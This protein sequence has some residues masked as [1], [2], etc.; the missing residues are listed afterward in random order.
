MLL[1][2]AYFKVDSVKVIMSVHFEWSNL[3]EMPGV[4]IM[5]FIC[6]NI[7]YLLQYIS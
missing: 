7:T 5:L 2:C 3:R 4:N 6:E 1:I